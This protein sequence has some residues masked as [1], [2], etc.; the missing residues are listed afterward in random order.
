VGIGAACGARCICK[1]SSASFPSSR[2]TPSLASASPPSS[3]Q[4]RER[5]ARA[6]RVWAPTEVSLFTVV[7]DPCRWGPKRQWAGPGA[8]GGTSRVVLVPCA[9]SPVAGVHVRP[10]PL[11]MGPGEQ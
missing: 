5:G 4:A 7:R 3:F 9:L 10:P 1:L 8:G 6:V 2:T 11:A